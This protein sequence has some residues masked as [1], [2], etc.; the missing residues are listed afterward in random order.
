M[1]TEYLRVSQAC[2]RLNMAQSTLYAMLVQN[3]VPDLTKPKRRGM[4]P[5]SVAYLFDTVVGYRVG[6]RWR[7]AISDTARPS[8]APQDDGDWPRVADIPPPRPKK[9]SS[10]TKKGTAQCNPE[11]PSSL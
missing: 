8:N 1:T 10:R 4:E 5:H 6:R 11:S 7:I 2:K 9:Q 3:E